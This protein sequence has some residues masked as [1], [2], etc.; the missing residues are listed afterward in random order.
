MN[1]TSERNN[2]NSRVLAT[3]S[4]AAAND[5]KRIRNILIFDNHPAS[6]R[7]VRELYVDSAGSTLSQ[8]Y[9]LIIAFVILGLAFV[10]VAFW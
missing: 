5:G 1:T 10:I 9:L 3:D 8:C 7:L 6:L 4:N 2:N